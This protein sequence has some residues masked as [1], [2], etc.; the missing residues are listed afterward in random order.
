MHLRLFR[1]LCLTDHIVNSKV[2]CEPQTTEI[3]DEIIPSK[4]FKIIVHRQKLQCND[5]GNNPLTIEYKGK[6]LSIAN[7]K[8]IQVFEY[9]ADKNGRNEIYIISFQSCDGRYKILKVE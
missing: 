1:G 2:V 4:E 3:R 7:L 8:N 5:T 9:D 6:T